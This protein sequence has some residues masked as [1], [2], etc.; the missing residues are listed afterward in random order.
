M[1]LIKPQHSSKHL[2]QPLI[3]VKKM[4][5]SKIFNARKF[6]STTI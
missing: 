3:I 4:E 6:N 1:N 2:F 5:N